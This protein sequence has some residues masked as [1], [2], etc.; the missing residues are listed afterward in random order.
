MEAAELGI[1]VAASG[2]NFRE[3]A[4]IRV[5]FRILQLFQSLFLRTPQVQ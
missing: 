4:R 2:V 5:R 3:I 1:N